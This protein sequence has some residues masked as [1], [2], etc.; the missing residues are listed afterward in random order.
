[1]YLKGE[2]C[3]QVDNNS[4]VR[5]RGGGRGEG[6]VFFYNSFEFKIRFRK[7]KI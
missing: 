3:S 4:Y 7:K 6:L 1:M 2:A 5:R